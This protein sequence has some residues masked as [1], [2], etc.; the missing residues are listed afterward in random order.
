MADYLEV[1]AIELEGIS[2]A[3]TL[4]KNLKKSSSR[5]KLKPR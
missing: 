2:N 3:G 4:E 1:E 5:P